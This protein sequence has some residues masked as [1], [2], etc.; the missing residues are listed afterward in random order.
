MTM[1]PGKI[2]KNGN[3]LSTNPKI[4]E[5]IYEILLT[6]IIMTIAHMAFWY[7]SNSYHFLFFSFDLN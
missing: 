7:L 2:A 6:I 1:L 4:I 3:E 5:V